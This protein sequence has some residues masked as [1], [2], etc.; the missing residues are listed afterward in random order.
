MDPLSEDD[1]EDDFEGDDSD[2]DDYSPEIEGEVT[3]DV[4]DTR[5]EP[6]PSTSNQSFGFHR[7]GR[8]GLRGG[9]GRVPD[10]QT[11]I[12]HC[13][14]ADR[15]HERPTMPEFCKSPGVKANI[16]PDDSAFQYFSLF[17]RPD[18]FQRMV[19]ETNTYAEQI[20]GAKGMFY[21]TVIY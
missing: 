15:Q 20:I 18:M 3:N 4:S 10:R 16:N 21:F 8:A 9:R 6:V 2:T 19:E 12:N 1:E 7:A 5:V 17:V 14:T 11:G 13:W